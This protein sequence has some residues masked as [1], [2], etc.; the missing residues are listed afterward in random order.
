MFQANL[1]KVTK[2]ELNVGQYLI[3]QNRCLLRIK[4]DEYNDIAQQMRAAEANI[5]L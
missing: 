1:S 4:G 2:T 5:S 3:L